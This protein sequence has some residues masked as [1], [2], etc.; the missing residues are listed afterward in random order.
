MIIDSSAIIAIIL[1]EPGFQRYTDII[2]NDADPRI[3]AFTMYEAGSVLL[4]RKGTPGV[5]MMQRFLR[6]AR[7]GISGFDE[8]QASRATTVYAKFG[9]GISPVGLN[10]GDCPVYA[11][12]QMQ[13]A[14]V[15]STSDE[16][17]RAG[18]EPPAAG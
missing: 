15:L 9:K 2:R 3:S 17:V 16:F 5:V 18:L 7:I 14:P 1:G 12:A 10:L 6:E 13:N 11:L 4:R 8:D